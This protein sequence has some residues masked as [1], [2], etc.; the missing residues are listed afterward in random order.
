MQQGQAHTYHMS[1][2]LQVSTLVHWKSFLSETILKTNVGPPPQNTYT[3]WA[4]VHGVAEIWTQLKWLNTHMC[5]CIYYE[6]VCKYVYVCVYI[7]PSAFTDSGHPANWFYAE[8][9][10]QCW[11]PLT[12]LWPML[13]ILIPGTI[14]TTQG[15]IEN[16]PLECSY[17]PLSYKHKQLLR[18]VLKS[19]HFSG[20]DPTP[21]VNWELMNKG[22][23]IYLVC[24]AGNTQSL[25]YGGNFYNNRA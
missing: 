15:L 23:L 9:N 16:L 20:G 8:I 22:E 12:W 18:P 1:I 4:V 21:S 19:C 14:L 13:N 11:K 6:Y 7:S 5:I 10:P 25:G 17:L 2:P 24:L 3:W